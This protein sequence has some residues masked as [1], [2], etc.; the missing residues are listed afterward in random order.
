[1]FCTE[2]IT[3]FLF[4]KNDSLTR[5]GYLGGYVTKKKTND[6]LKNEDIRDNIKVESYESKMSN[7]RLR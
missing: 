3:R 5:L 7:K 2:P 4:T 1:M 6:K